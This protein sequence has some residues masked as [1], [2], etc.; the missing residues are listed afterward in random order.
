LVDRRKRD[1]LAGGKMLEQLQIEHFHRSSLTEGAKIARKNRLYV[2]GWLMIDEFH[3]IER[4]GDN[5][6]L[7]SSTM[8]SIAY[9]GEK[10]VAACL[11]FVECDNVTCY[12]FVRKR[13]RRQCIG[14]TLYKSA[15][16]QYS[17]LFHGWASATQEVAVYTGV[18]KSDKFWQSVGL[19]SRW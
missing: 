8:I 6:A 15:T 13:L 16:E 14:T 2:P 3:A 5:N 12:M 1:Q 7:L 19:T 18:D 4:A 17:F 9:V 10:P 11:L